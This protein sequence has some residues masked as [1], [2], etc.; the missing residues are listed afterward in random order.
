MRGGLWACTVWLAL[1]LA[2]GFSAHAALLSTP[3]E[4]TANDRAQALYEAGNPRA[5][6]RLYMQSAR[7]GSAVAQFNAASMLLRGEGGPVNVPQALPLL[8]ASAEQGF[9]LAQYAYGSLFDTGLHVGRVQPAEAAKWFCRAAE[10]DH[11]DSQIECGTAYML[12]RGQ[13]RSDERAATWFLKAAAQGDMGAQYIVASFYEKGIGLTKDLDAALSWYA[14]AARQGDVAAAAK[15]REL[16][17]RL[18]ARGS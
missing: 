10:Q 5:A 1:S 11:V 12:G 9:V 18:P 2:G 6:L 13:P 4:K 17:E 15:A 16:A 14:R 7:S 3:E 8:R